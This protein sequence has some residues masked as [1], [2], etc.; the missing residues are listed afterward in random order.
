MK[1]I[2][3][4]ILITIGSNI[5]SEEDNRILNR[6]PF[7]LELAVDEKSFYDYDVPESP[8]LLPDN[9]LQIYPGEEIFIE[10]EINGD[11]IELISVV[12]EN[13]HPE[14]TIKIT[15][16]QN[17][18]GRLHEFMMLHVTNPFD[19]DLLYD[20]FIFILQNNKWTKTSII[21]VPAGLSS[22]ESWPDIIVTLA[23]SQ[24]KLL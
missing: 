21:P 17:S 11:G 24:F 14:K 5:Y 7:K 9:T 1:K 4:L 22:Y 10:V 15:F 23:L 20:S 12:S 6:E 3:F 13:I 8:Y 2:I 19:R 16:T 18:E